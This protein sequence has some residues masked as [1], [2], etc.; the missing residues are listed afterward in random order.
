MGSLQSG[1]NG[2]ELW[3]L[4]GEWTPLSGGGRQ[5]GDSARAGSLGLRAKLLVV[6][7][8]VAGRRRC[9]LDGQAILTGSAVKR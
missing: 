1:D 8:G 3:E 4:A 6:R 2:L 5:I 7:R 9:G